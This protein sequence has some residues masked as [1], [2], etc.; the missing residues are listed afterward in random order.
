MK[1][2][3]VMKSQVKWHIMDF[4]SSLLTHAVHEMCDVSQPQCYC[5]VC[6]NHGVIVITWQ[7]PMTLLHGDMELKRFDW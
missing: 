5:V 1:F 6:C 7:K 4:M 3:W 2:D